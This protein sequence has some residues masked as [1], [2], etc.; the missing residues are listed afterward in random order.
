M[1][2]GLDGLHEVLGSNLID[3]NVPKKKKKVKNCF[4]SIETEV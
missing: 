2:N 3:V 1:V 4:I